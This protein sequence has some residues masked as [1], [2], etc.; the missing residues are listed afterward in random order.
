V[1]GRF[2]WWTKNCAVK[3]TDNC[4][5]TQFLSGNFKARRI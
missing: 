1:T 5:K 3:F 2:Y 4:F